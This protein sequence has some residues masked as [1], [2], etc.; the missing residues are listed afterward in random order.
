M[1][2]VIVQ[3]DDLGTIAAIM[4]EGMIL[5]TSADYGDDDLPHNPPRRATQ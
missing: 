1:T 4:H 3:D 5:S 2:L